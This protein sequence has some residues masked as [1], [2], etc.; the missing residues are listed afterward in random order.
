[1]W[2]RQL[3]NPAR[4]EATNHLM[5]NIRKPGQYMFTKPSMPIVPEIP[6]VIFSIIQGASCLMKI[7]KVMRGIDDY[8]VAKKKDL[9]EWKNVSLPAIETTAFVTMD[10]EIVASRTK[11]IYIGYDHR[12]SPPRIIQP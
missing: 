2:V 3:P 6:A 9:F 5:D 4:S 12:F 1:V 7:H 10:A 11:C 8:P